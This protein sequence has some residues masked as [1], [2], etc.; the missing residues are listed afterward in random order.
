MPDISAPPIPTLVD[1]GASSNFIDSAFLSTL[2]L[3]PSPIPI[4]LSMFNGEPMSH[5]LITHSIT[6]NL[7]FP[8]SNCFQIVDL[9][10]ITLHPM[11]SIVLGLP[12]LCYTNPDVDWTR[13]QLQFHSGNHLPQVPHSIAILFIPPVSWVLPSA[14]ESLPPISIVPVSSHSTAT[15]IAAG[16]VPLADSDPSSTT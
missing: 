13:L 10:V 12:W 9:L 3:F 1:S 5:G 4:K 15:V 2:S 14:A 11:A 6:A 7:L 8:S 16:L